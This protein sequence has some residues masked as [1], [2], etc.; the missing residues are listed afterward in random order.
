MGPN[1]YFRENTMTHELGI[2]VGT[3]KDTFKVTNV[4]DE[5]ATI[6]MGYDFS[7]CS[8]ND[9][10]SWLAGNRRIA[11]QRPLRKLSV[12]EIMALNGTTIAADK[13]GQKVKSEQEQIDTFALA[14]ESQGI[15]HE[16]A[17]KLA[18]AAVKNPQL[19]N[20]DEG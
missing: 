3:V 11:A 8:D 15:D 12:D 1:E 2:L 14:F 20:V 5:T 19:L 10:R 7:H 16:T 13:A 9:I 6:T 17:M 4:N 18:T